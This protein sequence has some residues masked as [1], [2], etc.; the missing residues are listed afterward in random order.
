MAV[1][2]AVSRSNYGMVKAVEAQSFV[3]ETN[4]GLQTRKICEKL[5]V[6]R[7]KQAQKRS[8]IKDMKKRKSM[9][10]KTLKTHHDRIAKEGVTYAPGGF[11]NPDDPQ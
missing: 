7:K 11:G 4:V 9:K 2:Q 1:C 10:A 6:K 8:T 3:L 5:D